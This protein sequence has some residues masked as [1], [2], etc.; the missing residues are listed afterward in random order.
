L[1]KVVDMNYDIHM[2]VL[3]FAENQMIYKP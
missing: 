3:S 2:D 1:A